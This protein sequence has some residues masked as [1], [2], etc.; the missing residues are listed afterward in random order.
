MKPVALKE[1]P[2]ELLTEEP[3]SLCGHVA[4]GTTHVDVP[5]IV[6]ANQCLRAENSV[7]R[8]RHSKLIHAVRLRQTLQRKALKAAE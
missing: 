2:T 8:V 1:V 5:F 7:L 4:A 6:N 3:P